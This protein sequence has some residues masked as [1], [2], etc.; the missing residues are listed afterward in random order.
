MLEDSGDSAGPCGF[1]FNIIKI[2]TRFIKTIFNNSRK[3]ET[4]RN[5]LSKCNLYL[6]F[7]I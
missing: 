5:Y 1:L 4:I 7:L 3:D 6:Y 2:A